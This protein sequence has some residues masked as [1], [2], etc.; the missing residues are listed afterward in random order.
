[1]LPNTILGVVFDLDNTL[2]SSSLN[3]A[4]IRQAI[5]CPTDQDIL[6][7]VGNLP[8]NQQQQARKKILNFEMLDAQDAVILAG[9]KNLL[10]ML[11]SAD[12]PYAI[13][14]RNCKQAAVLKVKNNNID[15]PLLLTRENSKAKPAPDSVFY[16]AN[17]WQISSDNI[18]FVGDHLYDVQTA[19]NAKA[20]SC[21]INYGHRLPYEY[22]A[23]LVVKDLT[24]LISTLLNMKSL[25]GINDIR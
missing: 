19:K 3:F 9:T 13:V 12:I 15:I 14:T 8:A 5:N 21:L 25:E 1:L 23:N 4:D 22:L 11:D 16:I 24:E 2:V 7:F 20:M 17:Y 18:L 10:K 6:D